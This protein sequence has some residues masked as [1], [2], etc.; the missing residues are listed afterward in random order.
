MSQR[1]FVY[2]KLTE[3]SKSLIVSILVSVACMILQSSKSCVL[4][5]GGLKRK[6]IDETNLIIWRE[7]I[8]VDVQELSLF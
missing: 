5:K 4:A 8:P 2:I 6:D 7:K 3:P 1:T